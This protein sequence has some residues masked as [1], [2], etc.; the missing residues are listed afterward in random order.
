MWNMDRWVIRDRRGE[1]SDGDYGQSGYK[2]SKGENSD[3]DYGL[4]GD[5]DF[6]I[7][8]SGPTYLLIG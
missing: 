2:G 1:Q 8:L 7:C 4:G 3:G 5:T 6:T